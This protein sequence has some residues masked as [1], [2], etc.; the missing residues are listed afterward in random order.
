MKKIAVDLTPILPGGSNGGARIF[1]LE[2][3]SN[4]AKILPKTQFLLLVNKISQDELGS[5]DDKNISMVLVDSPL[6]RFQSDKNHSTLILYL[7]KLIAPLPLTLKQKLK[8]LLNKIRNIFPQR[9]PIAA[10]Q[11][12]QFADVLFCPFTRPTYY[13][14]GV[15]TV[16]VIYDLQYKKY[17]EFF[18]CSDV[19]HRDETF[20]LASLYSSKII[21]ISDYTRKKVIET[22]KVD[23]N[24]VQTILLQMANRALNHAHFDE[25]LFLKYEIKQKAYL[26]YPANFWQHKNHEMLL[27]AFVRARQTGLIDHI[28]LVCTGAIE[29]R[30]NWLRYAADKFGLSSSVIF[31]GYVT[32]AEY[33]QLLHNCCG[34]IFPSLYEG[35]GLPVI[36]AMA[37]GIPVACSNV[38]ALPEIAGNA[39]ILFDPRKPIEIKD[40]IISLVNDRELVASL[41]RRG[42]ERASEF[43]DT[44]QMAFEYVKVFQELLDNKLN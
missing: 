28:Q 3:V 22:G 33:Y 36:E 2:L 25:N 32:D 15:P 10:S 11:N 26:L 8:S 21:C 23:P 35:F 31:P 4:L 20:E 41:K 39:A 29:D 9:R 16:S 44:K 6:K 18:S 14:Q 30:L 37:A 43:F 13:M 7:R 24:K 40:S 1:V 38:T 34:L 12:Q 19:M 42:T 17:P 5:L 27:I